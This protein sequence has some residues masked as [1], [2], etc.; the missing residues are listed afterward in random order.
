MNIQ[1]LRNPNM[2]F[3]G[4][5]VGGGLLLATTALL[6]PNHWQ[7]AD[8][9]RRGTFSPPPVAIPTPPPSNAQLMQRFTQGKRLA[10]PDLQRLMAASTAT[11]SAST[12]SAMAD[13]LA[14]GGAPVA[15]DRISYDIMASGRPDVALAFLESR[16]D[17]AA[18][19]VW[20]LRF[21]LH[22]KTG[23]AQGAADLLRTAAMTPRSAPPQ[24][25][26]EA[27]YALATPDML[28]TA[29]EHGAI[30]RLS[31]SQALDLASWAN[32]AQRYDLIS[33]IDRAGTPGWRAGNPWLAMTL[34]QKSG[35]TGSAL[36][37]AALLPSG[38]DAARESIIMASGKPQAMRQYLLEQASASGAD[39]P[40]IAQRLLEKGFRPDAIALLRQQSANGAGND[41]SSAR[42]LYLMGPRPAGEDLD[43]LRSRAAADPH[44][45]PAYVEREQPAK[46]LAFLESRPSAD[47]SDMLVQRIALANAARD[48]AAAARALDGLLDGRQLSAAQLKAAATAVVP[49]DRAGRYALSLARARIAAG[50]AEPSDRLNLAWNGWD[51]GDAAETVTQLQ[52]YLRDRPDDRA[53]LRLMADAQSKLKGDAAARPWLERL[54]TVTP[55]SIE[56]A[57]LLNRLGRTSDA[58]AMVEMLRR[59]SPNDRRLNIML[60]QLL[61]A[62]GNPGRARKVLQP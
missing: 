55:P 53:A 27:A 24:D 58:M 59:A 42:M 57:Q 4:P 23:D 37:Y 9:I 47:S 13:A 48:R 18:P 51:R 38:R 25:V 45:L 56:Q 11:A 30:P 35:D 36:R 44:W 8:A 21:D 43:W 61:I 49:T 28:I 17:R 62:S 32:T 22:R 40:A 5:I 31:Q 46:A 39:R 54:L 34:A 20:R 1:A 15:T 26:V 16:P 19:A 60:S 50:Q 41:K 52:G 3:F 7:I 10:V 6:I 14:K 2:A 12:L 33:R 29:A